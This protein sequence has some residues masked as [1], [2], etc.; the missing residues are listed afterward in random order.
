MTI[1]IG[2]KPTKHTPNCV[3]ASSIVKEILAKQGLED[4]RAMRV[5]DICGC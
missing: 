1:G 2:N 5:L 3:E 4:L